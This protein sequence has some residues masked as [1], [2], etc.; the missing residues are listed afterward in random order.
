MGENYFHPL[1][2]S[3]VTLMSCHYQPQFCFHAAANPLSGNNSHKIVFR[4]A[5]DL[6]FRLN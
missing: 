6:R 2:N 3:M 4:Y 5:F 1:Y